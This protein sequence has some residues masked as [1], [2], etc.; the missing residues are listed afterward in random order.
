MLFAQMAVNLVIW[1]VVGCS[2]DIG[3]HHGIIARKKTKL[4]MST[5]ANIYHSEKQLDGLPESLDERTVQEIEIH[6]YS[7]YSLK[8]FH[9]GLLLLLRLHSCI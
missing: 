3:I 7:H 2:K 5:H 9:E 8:G 1:K 6:H 4:F